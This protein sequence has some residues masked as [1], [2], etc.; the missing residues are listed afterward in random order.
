VTCMATAV[1]PCA[2]S[3]RPGTRSACSER[4]T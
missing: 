4:T 3:P 1:R 2:R